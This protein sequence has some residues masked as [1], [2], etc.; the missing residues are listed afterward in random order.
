MLIPPLSKPEVLYSETTYVRVKF[1]LPAARTI[2][3]PVRGQAAWILSQKEAGNLLCFRWITGIRL[4]IA[5]D[6][7]A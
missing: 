5:I 3:G 2:G 4:T 6:E 1:L 7:T